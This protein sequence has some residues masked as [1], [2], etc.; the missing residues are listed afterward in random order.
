MPGVHSNIAVVRLS[1]HK[2]V[3]GERTSED[4]VT[5]RRLNVTIIRRRHHIVT[6]DALIFLSFF[7]FILLHFP[8]KIFTRGRQP[9]RI[10]LAALCYVNTPSTTQ[11]FNP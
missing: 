10:C 8:A 5:R 11:T 2:I 9:G 4:D 1:V 6:A 7:F 3:V